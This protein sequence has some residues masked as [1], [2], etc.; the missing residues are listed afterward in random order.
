M[1]KPV[2][3]Q[4]I[5]KALGLAKGTV[6][7]ALRGNP[8]IAASTRARV[9]AA[10]ER[11]GYVPDPAL[12]RLAALRWADESA[13]SRVS[14]ALVVWDRNDYPYLYRDISG[15]VRELLTLRGYGFE[16]QIVTDCPS[17]WRAAAILKARG[18]AGIL[19]L[20][21]RQETA[22]IGF[23]FEG[24]SGVEI[25]AGSGRATGLPQVRPDNF[26]NMLAA[27]ERVGATRPRSAAICLLSQERPSLTDYRNEA[28]ALY[29]IRDWKALGIRPAVVRSFA[30]GPEALGEMAYWLRRARIEAAIVP[31]SWMAEALRHE[32]GAPKLLFAQ[33]VEEGSREAGFRQDFGEIARRAVILLDSYIREGRKGANGQSETLV[34]SWPW[35]EPRG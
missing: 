34:V 26:G 15:A 28:A 9:A 11:M 22:W 2:R 5:A 16:E 31:N 12:R 33:A 30:G 10:A 21:S 23:P 14:V 1:G 8:R 3:L 13:A 19:A 29:A 24:F 27:A 25:H 17:P 32:R 7:M 20:A 35:L 18:V 6:S 4:D